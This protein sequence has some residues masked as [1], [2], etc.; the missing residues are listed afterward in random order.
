MKK[1][2]LIL[3]SIPMLGQGNQLSISIDSITTQNST[4]ELIF[5]LNYQIK[6]LTNE[7]ISFFLDTKKIIPSSVSSM[8][9]RPYYSV[10]QNDNQIDIPQILSK[11]RVISINDS[12]FVKNLQMQTIEI[13]SVFKNYKNKGGKSDNKYWVIKNKELKQSIITLKANEI[14]YFSYKFYWNKNRYFLQ[15]NLEYYLNEKDIYT[16]NLAFD[17]KK[18]AFK[19]QL[20]LEEFSLIEKDKNFIEGVFTSNKIEIDF[21]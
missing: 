20:T 21:R 11:N 18:F 10:F 12:D 17:L 5:T 16:I 14:K 9:Y 15:D 1:L 13:D 6:N 4:A 2:F 7:T 3:L 19:D 8:Q